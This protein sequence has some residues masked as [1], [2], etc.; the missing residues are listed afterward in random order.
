M[1][2]V[3]VNVQYKVA[4]PLHRSDSCQFSSYL[5]VFMSCN[6]SKYVCVKAVGFS[7]AVA[8]TLTNVKSVSCTVKNNQVLNKGGGRRRLSHEVMK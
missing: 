3:L 1:V 5:W 6:P 4:E 7:K 8:I 2:H